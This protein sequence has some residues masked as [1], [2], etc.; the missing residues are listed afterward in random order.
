MCLLILLNYACYLKTSRI[1]EHSNKD[2][3]HVYKRDVIDRKRHEYI[4][5]YKRIHKDII[6]W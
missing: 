3:L 6:V 1:C 4:Y 5:I 2:I